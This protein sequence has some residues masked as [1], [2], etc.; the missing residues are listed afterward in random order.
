MKNNMIYPWYAFLNNKKPSDFNTKSFT[1]NSNERR[2]ENIIFTDKRCP[3]DYAFNE[4]SKKI[5]VIDTEGCGVESKIKDGLPIE[6]VEK[7]SRP[8]NSDVFYLLSN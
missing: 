7:I 3:S 6:L 5:L 1:F 8:D 2:Y 4:I